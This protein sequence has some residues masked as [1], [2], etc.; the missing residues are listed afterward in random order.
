MSQEIRIHPLSR[1]H[2]FG[3]TAGGGGQIDPPVF[4]GFKELMTMT[5]SVE[6]VN[7]TVLSK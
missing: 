7:L 5:Q 2:N 1:K 3:K 4:L 6:P